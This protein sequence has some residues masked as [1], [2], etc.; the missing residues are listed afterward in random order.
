MNEE[1]YMQVI[2]SIEHYEE[3]V[4]VL[5]ALEATLVEHLRT[6]R[7]CLYAYEHGMVSRHPTLP[8]RVECLMFSEN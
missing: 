1:H 2:E 7:A 4:A 5:R 6:A 3:R 8:Y